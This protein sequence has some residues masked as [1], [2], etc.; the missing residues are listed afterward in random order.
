MQQPGKG[1]GS[2]Q[3][4]RQRGDPIHRLCMDGMHG[5]QR[6]RYPGGA[7]HRL[8]NQAPRESVDQRGISGMQHHRETVESQCVRSEAPIQK[9]VNQE[10]HRPVI[11]ASI[12]KETPHTRS[13]HLRQLMN[14]RH[15]RIAE[16]LK[17]IVGDEAIRKAIG[18][19]RDRDEDKRRIPR[20]QR[21]LARGPCD[22]QRGFQGY[23][24][25]CH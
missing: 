23:L 1:Y 19:N 20:P 13:E 7:G 22:R 5:E 21:R 3:H 18:V 24:A 8:T 25:L 9:R 14:V 17:L 2:E 15:Q 6:A 10:L 12:P 16:Q 4:V 11:I